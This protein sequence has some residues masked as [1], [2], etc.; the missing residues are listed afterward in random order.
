[1]N[2][3]PISLYIQLLSQTTDSQVNFLGP[4]S[5][6]GDISN[7]RW[8]YNF[9]IST[10]DYTG[11]IVETEVKVQIKLQKKIINQAICHHRVHS[12]TDI[13]KWIISRLM[14]I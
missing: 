4:E 1:M 13:K 6:L 12:N 5:L 10:V 14:L 2:K 8:T 11:I 9:E 3:F 7:F